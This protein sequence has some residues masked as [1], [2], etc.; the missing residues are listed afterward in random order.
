MRSIA[1]TIDA[2]MRGITNRM[3]EFNRLTAIGDFW[4]N[5]LSRAN[6]MHSDAA[7]QGGSWWQGCGAAYYHAPKPLLIEQ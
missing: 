7:S 1:K 6:Y 2:Q 5:H 4:R 3:L